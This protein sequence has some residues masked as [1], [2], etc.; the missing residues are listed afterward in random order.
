MAK[1]NIRFAWEFWVSCYRYAIGVQGELATMVSILFAVLTTLGIT[2]VVFAFVQ[3]R[4]DLLIMVLPLGIWLFVIAPVMVWKK[5]R[6]KVLEYEKDELELIVGNSAQYVH[7]RGDNW[8]FRIGIKTTGRKSVGNVGVVIT[9]RNGRPHAF[10]DAPLRP[11]YSLPN[12]SGS[13]SVKPDDTKFVEVC[14]WSKGSPEV[15]VHYH[16]SYQIILKYYDEKLSG[17]PSIIAPF[18]LPDGIPV[19]ESITLCVTGD[20]VPS[21]NKNLSI[22]ISGKEPL[23]KEV[24]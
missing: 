9:K 2:G 7:Q 22:D 16:T 21:V 5:E 4:L 19:G 20:N 14:S 24:E 6:E 23:W 17:L 10:P 11:A 13:F 15:R 12:E 8:I 18:V 1:K 3:N